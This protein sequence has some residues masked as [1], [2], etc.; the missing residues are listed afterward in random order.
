MRHTEIPRHV[1]R[2]VLAYREKRVN[3]IGCRP[4]Q[5]DRL[6]SIGFTEPIQEQILPLERATYRHLQCPLQWCRKTEE[7]RIRKIYHVETG[8]PPE[9]VQKLPDL[10]LLKSLLTTKHRDRQ[11]AETFR[12]DTDLP[13]RRQ[14]QRPCRVPQL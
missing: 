11:L 6:R 3:V 9:P 8:F 13:L 4:D 1:I 5:T 10:L 7:Q 2:V 14:P 12:V